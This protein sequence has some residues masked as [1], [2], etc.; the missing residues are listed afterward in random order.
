MTPKQEAFVR[1]YLLDSNAT[2]AAIRAGYSAKTAEQQ[3]PRLLGN[4]EISTA[5]AEAR[6]KI[7]ARADFT[8][9]EHMDTLARIRDMAVAAAQYSAASKCE[10]ARGKV[11]GFYVERVEMNAK[12]LGTTQYVA[13]IPR[14]GKQ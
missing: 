12:V 1:E 5:V 11:A 6:R 7:A 10:M 2:Q 3:G 9:D 4:V 8:V 13:E 14:R